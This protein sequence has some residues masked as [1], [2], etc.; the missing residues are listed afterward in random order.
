MGGV[1]VTISAPG[2]AREDIFEYLGTC[3]VETIGILSTWPGGQTERLTGTSMS[4]PHVAGVVALM[5][6]QALYAGQTL[7]PEDARMRIRDNA[8]R[9]GTAPLDSAVTGYTFDL[10]REGIIWAPSALGAP[11]PTPNLPPEVSIDSPAD[12]ATFNSGDTINFTGTATDPEQ[13]DISAQLIWTSNKDGA[14][15]N[16]ASFSTTLTNGSHV[17]TATV[18][19]AGGNRVRSNISIDIGSPSAP[20]MLTVDSIF[21]AMQ[22]TNLLTTLSV[23]DEF[24][25]PIDGANISITL[26]EW[27][28]TGD[29][30]ESTGTTN[31]QGDVQFILPNAAWGCYTTVVNDVTAEGLVW[32]G[33]TPD[34]AFCN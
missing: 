1:G 2:E 18:T 20:T 24:G 11:P 9:V 23:S 26:V 6:E 31:S 22:G 32:D 8:D 13:L 29:F 10:E 17:I 12:G 34:T 28:F 4:S 5:W 16:G 15:G 14:I 21:Y 33:L 27:L 3:F 7:L 25:P 19:D 30:W